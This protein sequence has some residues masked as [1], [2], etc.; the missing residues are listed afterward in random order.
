[1]YEM[2]ILVYEASH[3]GHEVLIYGEV[4]LFSN[5]LSC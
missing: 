5:S 2:A 1:M 3:F 4:Y